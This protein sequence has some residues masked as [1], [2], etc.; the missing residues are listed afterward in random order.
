MRFVFGKIGT[1]FSSGSLED[2]D[3]TV[4]VNEGDTL[5]TVFEEVSSGLTPMKLKRYLKKNPEI[6]STLQP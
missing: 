2:L 6:I 1:V 5:N 4:L 3:T